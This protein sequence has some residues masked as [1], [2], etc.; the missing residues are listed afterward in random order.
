[1]GTRTISAA[2][3]EGSVTT[4]GVVAYRAE[5]VVHMQTYLDGAVATEAGAVNG[6][7]GG[8]VEACPTWYVA[9]TVSVVAGVAVSGVTADGVVTYRAE[10]VVHVQTDLDGAVATEAGTVNGQDCGVV[11][12][13][14]TRYVTDYVAV[15]AGV[16]I[17]GVTTDCVVALIKTPHSN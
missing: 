6:Q 16:S 10:G 12:A 9:D 13:G 7:D 15:V 14:T 1:M 2:V 8:V 5:G 4:D 3:S 17:S 11:E